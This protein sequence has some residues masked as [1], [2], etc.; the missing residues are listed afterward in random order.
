MTRRACGSQGVSLGICAGG[1]TGIPEGF[2]SNTWRIE[3][4]Y[5][6]EYGFDFVEFGS[7]PRPRY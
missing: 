7:L 2:G 4:L 3:L 1:S 6:L 5:P